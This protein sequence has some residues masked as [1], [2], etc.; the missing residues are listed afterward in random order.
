MKF[1]KSEHIY[2]NLYDESDYQVK[3]HANRQKELVSKKT[4]KRTNS[5]QASKQAYKYPIKT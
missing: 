2:K 3:W 5:N 1:H 4:N